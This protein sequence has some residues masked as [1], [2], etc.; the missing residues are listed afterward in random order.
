MTRR[1]VDMARLAFGAWA[2]AR[3]TDVLHLV[4][5]DDGT[6]PRLATRVLGA[7]YV[8]QSAAG[9]GL[10]RRPVPWLDGA[11]DLVHAVSMLGVARAFPRHRR[12]ALTSSAVAVVFAVADLTEPVR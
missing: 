8:V 12:L 2:L 5:D 7:R 4:G 9:V 11:V 1:P 3:P 6:G 10:R